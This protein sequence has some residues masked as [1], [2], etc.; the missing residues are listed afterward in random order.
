MYRL[1]L[2]L[3]LVGLVGCVP[4]GD[5]AALAE[6]KKRVLAAEPAGVKGVIAVRKDA[7][8][9]DEVVVAGKVGG[10]HKPFTE[11]RAGFLLVD[12][13]LPPADDCDCPWDYCGVKKKDL[14][15]ARVRVK[16]VDGAGD[17][18]RAGAR[19]AF[20]I[21]ELSE[22]VVKGKVSRD[23]KGNVA[24]VATGIYVRPE[25]K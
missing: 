5:D 15:A 6:G 11:G 9:G 22:V 14:A 17:T 4:A 20:G 10:D 25:A 3:A 23:D 1:T 24:V 18:L 21:K 2:C 12:T 19:E 16:F 8:E 13:S 7:R